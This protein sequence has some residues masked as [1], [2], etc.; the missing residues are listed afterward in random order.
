LKE[1]REKAK[2]RL[3]AKRVTGLGTSASAASSSSSAPMRRPAA[4]TAMPAAATP[5]PVAATPVPAIQLLPELPPLFPPDVVET[6]QLDVT[7]LGTSTGGDVTTLGTSTGGAPGTVD[8]DFE[9]IP[10]GAADWGSPTSPAWEDDEVVPVLPA[11]L[12][13]S[14]R[15]DL[16]E[17]AAT[18]AGMAGVKKEEVQSVPSTPR[19]KGQ[20]NQ[21][22]MRTPASGAVLIGPSLHWARM[23]SW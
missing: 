10:F 17:V 15:E 5:M 6:P 23:A 11:D 1:A 9:E 4:A 18:L 12:S 19:G 2:A 20:E 3:E 14:A 8:M 7:A 21:H 16:D 22:I 13:R